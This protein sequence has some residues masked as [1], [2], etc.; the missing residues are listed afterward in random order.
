MIKILFKKEF[1]MDFYQKILDSQED[2]ILFGY[3]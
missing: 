2:L 1:V 3:F